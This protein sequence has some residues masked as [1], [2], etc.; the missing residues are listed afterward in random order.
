ME[1]PKITKQPSLKKS[2]SFKTTST[3]V[4]KPSLGQIKPKQKKLLKLQKKQSSVVLKTSPS[5]Q[6]EPIESLNAQ[7]A[8][9][10]GLADWK[11]SLKVSQSEH[12]LMS[13][14]LSVF[15]YYKTSVIRGTG[16]T[17]SSFS[18]QSVLRA[19]ISSIDWDTV[20]SHSF[21]VASHDV[22]LKLIIHEESIQKSNFL[23]SLKQVY[24]SV[25]DK[26]ILS[27]AIRDFNQLI[28]EKDHKIQVD[29][30]QKPGSQTYSL[31]SQTL[32]LIRESVLPVNLAVHGY[33]ITLIQEFITA[34]T[35]FYKGSKDQDANGKE[36]ETIQVQAKVN[37]KQGRVYFFILLKEDTGFDNIASVEVASF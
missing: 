23:A 18:D 16:K 7:L 24:K 28:S 4:S 2:M 20:L 37:L 17:Q 29:S 13:A 5:V 35:G 6:I 11:S 14:V 34:Y 9:A 32:K 31:G 15:N 21:E 19:D 36:Y 10:T 1:E 33:D 8:K 26:D 12:K 25:F 3:K 30:T 22:S 27:P